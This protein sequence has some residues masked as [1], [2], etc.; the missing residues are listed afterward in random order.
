[1]SDSLTIFDRRAVRRHRDRA[2]AR[3]DSHDFLVREVGERL[4]ER[5]L[6]IRRDFPRALDLGCHAGTLAPTLLATRG[7]EE[8][9]QCDLSPA[10][11][12]RARANGQPTLAVDEE[13]LPFAE[14]SFDLVVSVLNLHWVNDLPGTLLQI[15]RILKPDGLLLA[16]LIGGES[17]HEL[18]VSLMEAEMELEQGISPRVSPFASLND[19]ASLLQRADFRL[20]VADFDEIAV[21]YAD[22]FAAMQELRHMGE[23]NAVRARRQATSRRAT[24]LRAADIYRQRF[25]QADGRLP[26]TFE[27]LYLTGWAPHPSQQKPLRPGSAKTRLAEALGTVEVP[28]GDTARPG[29]PR[30]GLN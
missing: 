4:C 3:W 20:P 13:A 27:I 18:R 11:A 14:Q 9:V 12:A 16:A 21:T 15:R 30:D 24:L 10:M 1:M 25:A 5:L 7:I 22:P 8:V 2:A 17:L 28:A 29:K 6:D 23:S 26:L 19:T